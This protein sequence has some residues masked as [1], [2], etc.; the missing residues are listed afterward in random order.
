MYCRAPLSQTHI[1][2]PKHR[3]SVY[4][5]DEHSQR[6]ASA[7]HFSYY[8]AQKSACMQVLSHVSSRTCCS[9]AIHISAAD[10]RSSCNGHT[11]W[12]KHG[13]FETSENALLRKQPSTGVHQLGNPRMFK[14]A[15]PLIFPPIL[16]ILVSAD[17][18]GFSRWQGCQ[19]P[20]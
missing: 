5:K 19:E 8:N 14:H 10:R 4:T 9:L 15:G 11:S 1:A 18:T 16:L 12:E 2:P 6:K 13:T 3:L 7:Y 17:R 20:A